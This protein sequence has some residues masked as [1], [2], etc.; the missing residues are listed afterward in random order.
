MVFAEVAIILYTIVNLWVIRPYDSETGF[1]VRNS[2]Y[3][4]ELIHLKFVLVPVT[5]PVIN[6][7]R[8]HACARWV[9]RHRSCYRLIN[10]V[11]HPWGKC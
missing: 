3:D 10:F 4:A 8:S 9:P 7:G 6:P 5:W 11:D 2:T 1:A